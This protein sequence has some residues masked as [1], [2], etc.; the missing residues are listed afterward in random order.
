MMTRFYFVPS[1]TL[2]A[3]PPTGSWAAH[4]CPD[5]PA[6]AMVVVDN[7]ADTVAQDAWEALP[8]V[9]EVH[10]EQMG[11]PVSP[12]LLAAVRSWG[13]GAGHTHRQAFQLIRQRFPAWRH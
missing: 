9:T 3:Q 6:T 10:L 13:I 1:A 7:W 5:D 11:L 8:G 4:S 2:A 12:R